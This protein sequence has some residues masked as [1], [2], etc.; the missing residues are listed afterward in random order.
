MNKPK[1]I[2]SCADV[3][4][5]QEL[6]ETKMASTDYPTVVKATLCAI[7]LFN[8]KRGGELQRTKVSDFENAK[9][10]KATNDDILK[11]LTEVEK[12]MVNYFHREIR[13]K[14]NR[15]VPILLTKK[16]KTTLERI[17]QIKQSMPS[18]SSSQYIFATPA[19]ERPYRGH[20]VLKEYALEAQVSNP[21]M[22]TFT[23]LRS[24]LL[25]C[26]NHLPSQIW[27]RTSLLS[28]SGM[29]F[30][31]I[32]KSIANHKASFRRRK[33]QRFSCQSTMG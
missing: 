28:F 8:R 19:G 29:T 24:K 4:K 12:K 21:A 6:L 18:V 23:Q 17:L 15:S 33:W 22:F 3:S 9:C 16:I 7:S 30:G 20:D 14:F 32:A 26:L 31:F 11:G 25:H 1:L 13:G 2:P 5:V 27:I 10:G